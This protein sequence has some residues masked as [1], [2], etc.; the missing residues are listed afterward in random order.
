[1]SDIVIVGAP[2]SGTN[3]LRDVLTS[4]PGVATWPCDEINPIW[5]HGNT[6]VDHDELTAEHA[7][8]E[9]ARYV[10][11]R[12]EAIRR[13]HDAGVVV[14]K[15]CA[16]SLR[17]EFARAVL[18]DARYVFITRDGIDAAASA[19]DRWHAP[20][21]LRYTARKVRYVPPGD[22]AQLGL[23]FVG[24]AVRRGRTRTDRAGDHAATAGL[25][26]WWGPKPADWRELM[27]ERPLDEVCA[28]QW[29]RCVDNSLRGLAGL[30][31]DRLVRVRYEDYV[32]EPAAET[33]RIMDAL[34][35]EGRAAVGRVSAT[36]VGKG[37]QR[38]GAETVAR[39][40]ALVGDT[41]ARV[42]DA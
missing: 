3:M 21:D 18:P 22:L 1:M 19:M 16:T 20:F 30:P 39:L 13:K 9:V 10:R 6:G 29:Q 11:G 4:L 5:K 33:A 25:S 31:E 15:T 32:R 34:G 28:L 35:L 42:R 27:T 37:R 12:V 24:N 26:S 41:V 14:E 7:R 2:R 38:L 23:R 40:E 8:P 36:S 17:V